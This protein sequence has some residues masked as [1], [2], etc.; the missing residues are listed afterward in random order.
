MPSEKALKFLEAQDKAE[1]LNKEEFTCPL[2]GGTAW[3]G[4]SKINNHLHIRCKKCGF[5]ILQ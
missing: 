3:W 4:R 5:G 1:N 2:C